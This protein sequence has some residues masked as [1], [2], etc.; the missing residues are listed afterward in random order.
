MERKINDELLRWSSDAKKPLLLYGC[1]CVGKTYSCL[2]F[3]KQRYK[4]VAYFDCTNNLELFELFSHEKN[5]EKIILKLQMISNESIFQYDTLIIFDNCNYS[6]LIKAIKIFSSDSNPYHI[7][8]VTDR[9]DILNNV[10]GEELRYLQ[11]YP[12]DFEEFL[13]NSDKKQLVDF[14][15]DS[16]VTLSPMPFH[17]M[18]MDS[19]FD[20]LITGGMPEVVNAYFN[21]ESFNIIESIKQRIIS[22]YKSEISMYCNLNSVP[23]AFEVY[24]I[25]PY[26]NKKDNHKFQY[27]LIK[28]GGRSKDYEEAINYLVNNNIVNRSYKLNDIGSPLFKNKDEDSFKLY[29]NDPGLLYTGL[30]LNKMK[31]LTDLDTRRMLIENNIAN[32]LNSLGYNL[33]YYQSDGKAL[34][35]FIV[36]DRL[37]VITPIEI[38]DMKLV[39]SK[40]LSIVQT[41]FNM[42]NGIKISEANFEKKR[43]VKIIP[44]YASF[45]LK[46]LESNKN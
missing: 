19:Y 3:G 20:Y 17:Q 22:I 42:D 43:N 33:F 27:G 2:S 40:S 32:T 8:I 37:A 24:D 12:M 9:K 29:F 6:E 10:K 28:K 41:K 7:I 31:L 38:A 13:N 11:M 34:V 4:N 21:K 5:I 25:L 15:K 45:C 46:D 23:K 44:C 18:A 14:I 16:F 1:R 35:E 39:K 26:Q 30:H 36:Q